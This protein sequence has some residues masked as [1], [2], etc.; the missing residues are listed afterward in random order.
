M[1]VPASSAT[2]ADVNHGTFDGYTY[3][4]DS[5]PIPG[6]SAG[7]IEAACPAGTHAVGG[8]GDDGR[9]G[10]DTNLHTTAPYDGPDSGRAPDDGWRLRSATT[11]T[12]ITT[13]EVYVICQPEVPSYVA[14]SVKIAAGQGDSA[15][16]DCKAG[17]HVAAGGVS[18][19][20]D[21]SSVIVGATAPFDDADANA[22]ADDGWRGKAGNEGNEP[23]NVSAHAIC[24]ED[25]LSYKQSA[26]LATGPGTVS[27]AA[28]C[29]HPGDVTL[30]GGLWVTGPVPDTRLHSSRP[31]DDSDPDTAAND[32]WAGKLAMAAE[33]DLTVHVI[34][35]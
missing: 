31:S 22:D 1:L 35:A 20:G 21:I 33:I 13:A 17:L 7:T 28:P 23:R 16:A 30:G 12:G 3:V 24:V 2:A 11:A 6:P 18:G 27:V 5:S 26:P 32:D 34:C 8:G 10:S 29:L 9:F 14:K 25:K 4:S 19:S 15:K